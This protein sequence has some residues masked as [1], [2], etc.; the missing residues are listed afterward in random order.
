[1]FLQIEYPANNVGEFLLNQSIIRSVYSCDKN[2]VL[3]IGN[4]DHKRAIAY[5]VVDSFIIK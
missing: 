1:M 3:H 5:R 2:N 4:E